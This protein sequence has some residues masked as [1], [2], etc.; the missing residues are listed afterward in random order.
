MQR[1]HKHTEIPNLI[2]NEQV[3]VEVRD[4]FRRVG[5]PEFPEQNLWRV[6]VAKAVL[7]SLE[8]TKLRS[9]KEHEH[10]VMDAKNWFLKGDEDLQRYGPTDICD[11]AGLD[12]YAII[13]AMRTEFEKEQNEV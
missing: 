2:N 9:P 8:L 6:V 4:I 5:E 11:L 3:P 12:G 1:L 7:D 13:R 10:T